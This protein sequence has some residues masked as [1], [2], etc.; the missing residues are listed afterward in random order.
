MLI[1][2]WNPS[3]WKAYFAQRS[4]AVAWG[5][6]QHFGSKFGSKSIE[7]CDIIASLCSRE[8][9]YAT[10][11]WYIHLHYIDRERERHWSPTGSGKGHVDG[12][13]LQTLPPL[14]SSQSAAAS[15]LQRM[16]PSALVRMEFK[17]LGNP[18]MAWMD[19]SAFTFYVDR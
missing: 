2:C 5:R 12:T 15:G 11:I 9:S 3:G 4:S 16:A 7:K 17:S 8:T 1:G 19:P 10:E 14:P 6:A 18:S 13:C